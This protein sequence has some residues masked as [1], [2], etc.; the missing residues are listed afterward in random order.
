MKKSTFFLLYMVTHFAFSHT[1]SIENVVLKHWKIKNEN[2]EVVGSFC[3]IK[4]RTVYIENASDKI[5]HFPLSSLSNEDQL[6]VQKKANWVNTINNDFL[7][8]KSIS[9]EEIQSNW[10][11][12]LLAIAL[13]VFFIGIM[14]LTFVEKKKSKYLFPMFLVASMMILYGFSKNKAL[15]TAT[16]PEFM[17]SAFTPFASAVSTTFDKTYFYVNSK[18]IP[19][20][21]MMVGISNHGWQQQVPIP[22]CYTGSNAWSIPLN[23]VIAATPVP[24]SSSHFLK[25][26]IAIAA[27]GV[28]IFNYHTNT[29]VD[30]F[31][32]GQLDN[33]GGHCGR[34][35]DYHY[36]IAPLH[37]I[38][39]AQTTYNLPIAFGLDGFAVYGSLEPDGQTMKTLDANHGHYGT[40]GVY[41]YHGTNNA[42]Y[43]IG[44]MV[45]QVTEDSNLQIIPQ[46]QAHPIRNENWTPLSGALITSCVLNS[47]NNGYSTSYSLNGLLG[48]A[49]NFSWNGKT[50]TFDYITPTGITTKTYTGFVQ[51][52]IPNLSNND[53]AFNDSNI[54]VYP[55]PTNEFLNIKIN[56]LVSEKEI[57]AI[58]IY[59]IKGELI[60]KTRHFQPKVDTR[61]L[62]KG[63]Y[64]VRIQFKNYQVTKT[65]LVK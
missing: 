28:P 58:E 9:K 18:G 2:S 42:P 34:G 29:G 45:G 40:D 15:S 5:V 17:Q 47:N 24:V 25:G 60:S 3:M 37:L 21:E 12:K 36:H 46:A 1:V 39:L 13:V 22:Q 57:E 4:N 63:N 14:A 56:N 65:F 35:D 51:C 59:G 8:K 27:N 50:Y 55:N 54:V 43:M 41:H 62:T 44:R 32:D 48:Y 10:N 23:P 6:Y 61:N 38:T 64:W 30:S 52:S 11:N 16:N 49:T 7:A 26:A 31:L 19:N 33:Y 20:H 53:M